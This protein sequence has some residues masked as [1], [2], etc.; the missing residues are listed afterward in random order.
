MPLTP[1]L[2]QATLGVDIVKPTG[3]ST[4][5]VNNVA[6]LGAGAT[7][8]ADVFF[9]TVWDAWTSAERTA[10]QSFTTG[11]GGLVIAGEGWSWYDAG[12]RMASLP[13]NKL[14]SPL[15]VLSW[16]QVYTDAD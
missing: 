5:V 9:T 16:T 7:A 4:W 15:N 14:L 13:G 1:L 10:I 3:S 2:L 11:G 12:Y 6:T 8:T